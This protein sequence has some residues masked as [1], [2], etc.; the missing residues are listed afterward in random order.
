MAQLSTSIR[1]LGEVAKWGIRERNAVHGEMRRMFAAGRVDNMRQD[2]HV[3]GAALVFF[4]TGQCL[5]D[6]TRCLACSSGRY[7]FHVELERMKVGSSAGAASVRAKAGA[8]TAP[9]FLGTKENLDSCGTGFDGS[10]D[11]RVG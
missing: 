3:E 6:W 1:R 5:T 8:V 11:S 10:S 7:P 9:S 2:G 4:T